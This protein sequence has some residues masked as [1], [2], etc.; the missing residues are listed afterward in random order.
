MKHRHTWI[1]T[2]KTRNTNNPL[3]RACPC[4]EVQRFHSGRWTVTVKGTFKKAGEQ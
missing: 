2:R 4:G 1:I 3:I